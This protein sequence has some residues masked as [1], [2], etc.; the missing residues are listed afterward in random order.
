MNVKKEGYPLA[1]AVLQVIVLTPEEVT[2]ARMF[3]A[4]KTMSLKVGVNTD[5][6]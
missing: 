1:V 3:H 6:G 5:A 4:L 2:N